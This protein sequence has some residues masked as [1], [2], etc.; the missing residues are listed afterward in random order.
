LALLLPGR[1]L[2]RHLI[3]IAQT[4]LGALLIHLTGGRIE[5]HFHVFGSLAILAFYRDWRV[6]VTASAVVV[7]DHYMRGLYFPQSVYGTA[8]SGSWRWLE[9][10]AWVFFEDWF[11][12]QAC[13]WT[14]NGMHA[15]AE[16]EARLE[17]TKARI[18]SIVEGRTAELRERTAQ[19]QQAKEAAES[20]N[21][22]KGEF[23][24]NMSH[25]IRTPMN[26]IIGMTS[27]ALDTELS[28]LQREYLEMSQR[29][30][31]SL[32]EVVND[33]LDFSKIEAGKLALDPVPF[34]LGDCVGEVVKEMSLRATPSDWS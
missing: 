5:T 21:R 29:S 7:G 22:V 8:S 17:H 9:H 31:I 1:L 27:L 13:Q 20:A 24:A 25:E 2:T 3:A 28:P 10:G 30:A 34:S 19:L 32:L 4:L 26:G 6:L 14:V 33:I 18:E 15:T 11:L 23:L 12:I 16:R